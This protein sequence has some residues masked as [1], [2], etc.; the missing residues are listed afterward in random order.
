MIKHKIKFNLILVFCSI[1]LINFSSGVD[2]MA[3]NSYTINYTT[4]QH[5][6]EIYSTIKPSNLNE[7]SWI[8]LKVNDTYYQQI[9][10]TTCSTPLQSFDIITTIKTTGGTSHY[11]STKG[12]IIFDNNNTNKTILNSHNESVI[13]YPDVEVNKDCDNHCDIE[14]PQVVNDKLDTK[15]IILILSGLVLLAAT[16]Y[17]IFEHK[18]RTG[19]KK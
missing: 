19:G 5:I 11:S 7:I 9:I 16:L 10:N 17:F 12:E 2:L 18:F 3:C 6:L 4:P 14:I 15:T 13:I 8:F 1:L